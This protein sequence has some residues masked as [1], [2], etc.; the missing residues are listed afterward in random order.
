MLRRLLLLGASWSA[1]AAALAQPVPLLNGPAAPHGGPNISGATAP[2]AVTS[3][4]FA[5]QA[6]TG[7]SGTLA[8]T[9]GVLTV[10][11]A[12]AAYAESNVGLWTSFASNVAAIT[13][14]GLLVERAATNFSVNQ[15]TSAVAGTPG[16]APSG[17]SLVNIPTGITVTLSLP[18]TDA[19]TGFKITR[20]AFSGTAGSTL[21]PTIRLGPASGGN[22]CPAAQG[23]VWA[24]SAFLALNAGSLPVNSNLFV[25]YPGVNGL[26]ASTDVPNST[27]V[28]AA[29]APL[30]TIGAT[31]TRFE[32][33]P[34]YAHLTV[35][36]VYASIGFPMVSGNA[37]SFTIDV[38]EPQLEKLPSILHRAT[39]P[40]DCATS[41]TTGTTRA[42][43]VVT[44]AGA[45]LTQMQ[46][47]AVTASL[48]LGPSK[49]RPS[50]YLSGVTGPE[51]PTVNP[52]VLPILGV[53]GAA[54]LQREADGGISSSFSA[55]LRTF[56]AQLTNWTIGNPSAALAW[57]A[58]ALA[59]SNSAGADYAT[60]AA[61]P[62]SVTA[63][64][65][66]TAG[67]SAAIDGY[68]RALTVTSA[69]LDLSSVAT[70]AADYIVNGATSLGITAAYRAKFEGRSVA[71]LG[72]WDEVRI[73]GMQTGGLAFTDITPFA[74][75]T[76][77]VTSSGST[78]ILFTDPT[79]GTNPSPTGSVQPG[80]NCQP[81]LVNSIGPACRISAIGVAS[82]SGAHA[83]LS[84]PTLLSI[85]DA[86]KILI[87]QQ[88]GSIPRWL[89][90]R[91][92]A[93]LGVPDSEFT[94]E[95]RYF[96]SV[97]DE[98]LAE[99]GIPVYWTGGAASVTKAGTRLNGAAFN[100]ASYAGGTVAA[101]SASA[102][103]WTDATYEGDLMALAGVPFT[104]GRESAAT[105]SEPSS[106]AGFIAYDTS[107]GGLQQSGF[108]D[109]TVANYTNVDPYVT[110]GDITSGLLPE[111]ITD[112]GSAAGTGDSGVQAYNF[113]LT[114]V[115]NVV[116]A[117]TATSAIGATTITVAT[118][119]VIK[120]GAAI[121][122]ITGA[123]PPGTTVTAYS[124]TT[125]TLS[126][127]IVSPGVAIGDL[128][129][130]THPRSLAVFPLA[131][132]TDTSTFSFNAAR[133]E[134]L[135]RS[136]AL[137]AAAGRT[138]SPTVSAT[139]GNSVFN[140][141]DIIQ[142]KPGL[143]GSNAVYDGNAVGIVNTDL[144]GGSAAYP[145]GS[146]SA[147]KAIRDN[148][149]NHILGLLWVIQYYSDA[150]I[151]AGL[152]FDCLN[153]NFDNMHYS[154]GH[155][156]DAA[157][158]GFPPQ[159]YVREARR[160]TR[161]DYAAFN[162]NDVATN[163]VDGSAPRS[164]LSFGAGAYGID[165]HHTQRIVHVGRTPNVASFTGSISGTTLTV[166]SGLTGTVAKG[167]VSGTNVAAGQ[168]ITGQLSGTAGGLGTYS[169]SI[170]N[171]AASTA[172][173]L[174]TEVAWNEGI[175]AVTGA[176]GSNHMA[177]LPSQA[178]IPKASDCSNITVP[179]AVNASHLGFGFFRMELSAM[180]VAESCGLLAAMAIEQGSQPD[181][182]L[183][184]TNVSGNFRYGDTVTAGTF[185]YRLATTGPAPTFANAPLIN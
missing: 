129:N 79:A 34:L 184:E 3:L 134:I 50:S 42:L 77:G 152:Q 168:R 143:G 112:P 101:K 73:G 47:A 37:Y 26:V 98:M 160:F 90:T 22:L 59:V 118:S 128:I 49:W 24:S 91:I 82:G 180:A 57:K 78:D 169:V 149:R 117:A 177:P 14:K 139:T 115:K 16:T 174:L 80:L 93:K 97:Y 116:A 65:L 130:V 70:I 39:S 52:M 171:T 64:T 38:I 41:N 161:S 111:I 163:Q 137:A 138:Y 44:I 135:L 126:A 109:N 162:Y 88:Y 136:F 72:S 18:G 6:Y 105:Y 95:S 4:N 120:N 53:N 100:S 11:R 51:A 83:T 31:A 164:A 140:F 145:T 76:S 157:F 19:T 172:I 13:N 147:R 23:Q 151:P 54:A 176:A 99:S 102:K 150:R 20:Y 62:P 61:A 121:R 30:G 60:T 170:S 56:R 96:S 87:Y 28:A 17:W 36:G 175:L 75:F 25:T 12:S 158:P 71:I 108:P 182:A 142:A 15:N 21:T 119:L 178:V 94:F 69:A 40:I 1:I 179:F 29:A 68:I 144:I 141:L 104:V 32:T 110:A 125:V 107:N 2:P 7:P 132:A 173:T 81:V 165:S 166:A 8:D 185:A 63:A 181:L 33:L 48:T 124:G 122:M 159:L 84:A 154:P 55:A 45:L 148:H 89:M 10:T 113:R 133:Y 156:D 114:L 58:T 131:G 146:Y 5:T 183:V 103:V 9:T 153:W 74:M 27:V 66:G 86:T 92:A 35:T 106:M 167:P 85:P 46:G 123:V 127:A 67:G 155:P 43:S